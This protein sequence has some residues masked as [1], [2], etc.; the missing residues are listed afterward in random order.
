[1]IGLSHDANAQND[2]N[3]LGIELNGG[4]HEYRGDLGSSLFFARKPIYM[5]TGANISAY[6]SPSFD[7][8]FF[9]GSGDVGFYSTLP[10]VEEPFNNAGFTA[11]LFNVSLGARYKF[12]NDIIMPVESKI[13][14]YLLGGWGFQYIHSRINNAAK[15]YTGFVGV[16]HGGLGVQYNINSMFGLRLQSTANYMFNDIMDGFPFTN[17]IHKDNDINDMTMTHTI[18]VVVN[19][20]Y[21]LFGRESAGPKKM[22]DSDNDGVPNKFDQCPKTPEGWVVDS[23]GCPKDSDGDGIF[24][25]ADSCR[26]TP[27]KLEFNGCPD[28]DGDGIQDSKDRCPTEAGTAELKGCPDRDGDGVPDIDDRCPDAAG[29]AELKGCP[30]RDGDGVPDIDDKCPDKAGPAEHEG[31]PDSDGDGVYDNV[32][33]CPDVVGIAA[34]KGCPE[35][36]KEDV[37]KIELAAQGIYFDTNKATIQSK[38]F[39]N[40]NTLVDLLKQY[41]EANVIIEGHTDNVGSAEANKKLSQERAEAVRQYL[42]DKGIAPER[43]T[44]IGYGQEKPE[45]DNAT[46]AGR[47]KNRRVYFQIIY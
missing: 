27:G 11:R 4:F 35:I 29:S 9:G 42:I 47:T 20:P 13:A 7:I 5:Y 24:D 46:A 37:R 41:P 19:L 34:N 31:C 25:H 6:F 32:D 22:K 39:T 44:A 28:T 23:V 17:G 14:P 43:L 10:Y 16:V 2:Q 40:L 1:M 33:K 45:Y 12:N 36:K 30:D 3:R 8:S 18:G 26:Y 21:D 15:N 38:S